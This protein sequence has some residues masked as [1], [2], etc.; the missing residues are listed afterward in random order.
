MAQCMRMSVKPFPCES[1]HLTRFLLYRSLTG[2]AADMKATNVAS[3]SGSQDLCELM[4]FSEA[5]VKHLEYPEHD[6]RNL[7]FADG[8]FDAC[9]ADQVLE[10]VEEDPLLVMKECCRI[11]RR[12]G[13]VVQATVM[14]YPI[15]HG[16][17][18]LW[19]FTPE[20]MTF[21]FEQ[22][23]LKVV[24]SGSWGGAAAVGLITLG[25]ARIPVPKSESHP[26]RK[27]ATNPGRDWPIAVWAIGRKL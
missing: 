17:M 27:I 5:A 23:G 7:R 6:L 2:W 1:T 25:L 8:S 16:P 4:G 14:T 9:I 20:G 3:I 11:V 12:E 24:S 21:L 22:A 19:R 18:D 13:I 15:H 10:H 26:I